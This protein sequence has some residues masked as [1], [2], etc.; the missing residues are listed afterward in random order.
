[1]TSVPKLCSTRRFS[2][3]TAF[4]LFSKALSVEPSELYH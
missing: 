2:S 1:M 3:S 4:L